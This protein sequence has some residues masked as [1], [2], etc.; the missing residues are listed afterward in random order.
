[1]SAQAG[2]H[3]LLKISDGGT[4]EA[5]L[6]L[7]AARVTAF[8]LTTDAADVT[9]LGAG[10]PV[11]DASAGR[12]EARI[13]LQ[14]IFKDSAA[15]ARLRSAAESGGAVRYR[16]GFPNGDTYAADFIVES[17]RREGS[18]EGLETFAAT[19][20]RTGPGVWSTA[21]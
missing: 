6:T 16:L 1:M 19:F 7:G 4:P 21:S 11:Y 3:L 17:Y 20:R 5:F 18:H 8:D 12:Q 14:G 2:K 13:T 15:E 9:P 10:V